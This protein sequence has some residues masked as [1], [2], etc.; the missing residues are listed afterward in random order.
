VSYKDSAPWRLGAFALN[1]SPCP[2]EVLKSDSS[3]KNRISARPV[4]VNFES[5]LVDVVRADGNRP[6]DFALDIKGRSQVGG[7]VHHV[8]RLAIMR[9]EP[10]DFMRS[11]A[12]IE[13]GL[14]EV[15]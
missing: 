8:V 7:N 3:A 6:D 12:W 4:V 1:S 2:K 5:T 9:G 10:V 11:Q 14:F 13:R 15:R